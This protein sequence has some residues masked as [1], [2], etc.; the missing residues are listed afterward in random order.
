MR[1]AVWRVVAPFASRTTAL[2]DDDGASRR[3][4]A[5][6]RARARRAIASSAMRG[7]RVR[8]RGAVGDRGGRTRV[9]R[10]V[11]DE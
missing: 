9:A 6:S 4:R 1:A 10:R 11:A 8:A 3:A 7:A 5:S 2:H